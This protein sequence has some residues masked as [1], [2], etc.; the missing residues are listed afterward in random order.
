MLQ[1]FL[2]ILK[3]PIVFLLRRPVLWLSK[4]VSSAPDKAYIFQRLSELYQ[5]IVDKP[6]SKQ[7]ALYNLDLK[8]GT[9]IIFSDHHKGNRGRSDEFRF[10]EKNY[11]AALEYYDKK[12][13]NYINL[14]DAEEFWKFNIFSIIKHNEATFEAEKKFVKRN[15]YYK[16]YGNHDMFWKIDPFS[17]MF[18]R[19]I[20]GK[21]INIYG[22][23]V[24]RIKYEEGK[25]ID[26]FCTHGHQGDKRS[27]GNAFSIW[28]VTYIWAPLQ[29]F[30]DININTP[31][32][33]QG[34][35]T[36]H[37]RLMYEWSQEQNNLI[38]VTGH[39]HQPIFHS[40]SHINAL[41]QQLEEALTSGNQPLANEISE[42]IAR[43][44]SQC[45]KE[46]NKTIKYK[47]TYFNAG[48]CCYS[49]HSITGI[50]IADGFIRLVNW[51]EDKD[52]SVREV[53]EELPLSE[54]K[55]M[56]FSTSH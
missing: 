33:I 39:T 20:Y 28:F 32:S 22:A 3:A 2:E 12:G 29:S 21:A 9:T 48:C 31:A 4:K 56:F 26:V 10:S 30:L 15:A 47:P 7:G 40:Y 38:L 8:N 44:P 34:E 52:T 49:D 53:M 13:A 24:I 54:L 17:N 19:E 11:L 14:G 42:K 27:D 1:K 23:I 36:L 55:H 5:D 16:I 50:E 41:K 51:H 25:H 43:H 46:A 45:E 35:K 6:K 18:L 37:N